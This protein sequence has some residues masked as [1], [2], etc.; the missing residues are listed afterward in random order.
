MRPTRKTLAVASCW[1]LRPLLAACWEDLLWEI[2]GPVLRIL[3]WSEELLEAV[4]CGACVDKYIQVK[5]K[6]LKY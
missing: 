6:L 4:E 3:D 5:Y 2:L 1:W